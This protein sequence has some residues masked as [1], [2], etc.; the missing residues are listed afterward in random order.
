M[1]KIVQ[2]AVLLAITLAVGGARCVMAQDQP[3]RLNDSDMKRLVGK[4]EHDA[5]RFKDS[6]HKELDRWHWEDKR[7]RDDMKSAASGFERATDRLKDHFHHG[8]ARPE[9]VQEVLDR[10]AAIDSFIVGRRMI[11]RA[12]AD[13]MALRGDLDELAQAYNIS[14]RWPEGPAEGPGR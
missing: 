12:H 8:N 5:D 13:W 4:T 7:D 11:P 9:D 14:W 2:F 10:G 6:L 3:Y 1:K